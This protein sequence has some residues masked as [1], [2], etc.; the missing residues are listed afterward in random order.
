[1]T[2]QEVINKVFALIDDECDPK[3][4]SKEEYLEVLQGV[5]DDAEI[6]IE[7]VEAELEDDADGE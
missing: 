2:P 5:R 4:M 7:S 6:R 3:Q 1:M